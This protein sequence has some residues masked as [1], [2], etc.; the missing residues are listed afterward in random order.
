MTALHR[1]TSI[2]AFDRV[3][4]PHFQQMH[5]GQTKGVH[6][7]GRV[8]QC[9]C[10]LEGI[11]AAMTEIIAIQLKSFLPERFPKSLRLQI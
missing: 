2:K 11:W 1:P 9:E 7:V 6:L 4:N 5:F 8:L 3:C 10:T